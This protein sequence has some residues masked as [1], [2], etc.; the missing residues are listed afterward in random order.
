MVINVFACVVSRE[1]WETLPRGTMPEGA[2]LS[3]HPVL[4]SEVLGHQSWGD[5]RTLLL[6]S[7]SPPPTPKMAQDFEGVR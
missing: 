2:K 7:L 5:T 3:K 6:T 4:L 1:G